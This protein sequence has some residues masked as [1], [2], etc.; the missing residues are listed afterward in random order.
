MRQGSG[1]DFN[2]Y[3]STASGLSSNP[4]SPL[5][6]QV[7]FNFFLQL[8]LNILVRVYAESFMGSYLG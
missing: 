2:S 7:A 8:Q 4:P 5:L 1:R 3:M 6:I